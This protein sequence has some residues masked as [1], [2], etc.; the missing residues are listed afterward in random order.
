MTERHIP[1]ACTNCGQAGA[2]VWRDDGASRVLMRLTNGFHVENHRLPGCRQTII[3]SICDE[4]E[5][6]RFSS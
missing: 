5:P 3:C 2:A 6:E 1:S 4:I